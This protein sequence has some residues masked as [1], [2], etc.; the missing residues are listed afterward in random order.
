MKYRLIA[1]TAILFFLFF[2]CTSQTVDP[3]SPR[4]K[5]FEEY[6]TKMAELGKFNGNV[7]VAEKGEVIYQRSIGQ[8]S[9]EVGDLLDVGQELNPSPKK[10]CAEG[11]GNS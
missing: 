9:A 8:R 4:A 11:N 10:T 2:N 3:L 1:T 5:N 6:I 7:L